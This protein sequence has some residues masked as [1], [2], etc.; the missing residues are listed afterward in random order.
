M[1]S[2]EIHAI[3]VETAEVPETTS[4]AT[5][6]NSINS[7]D[8][9]ESRSVKD[10]KIPETDTTTTTPLDVEKHETVAFGSAH[11][12]LP[13]DRQVVLDRVVKTRADIELL[14][15]TVRQKYKYCK[16][17]EN[18]NN[19]LQDFVGTMMAHSDLKK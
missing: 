5:G 10:D 12:E 14:F 18:E 1:T 13:E 8:Q 3:V 17:L 9:K 6:M 7:K 15:K 4:P 2:D 19:Y 16:E 11:L